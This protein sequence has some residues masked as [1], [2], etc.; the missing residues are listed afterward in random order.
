MAEERNQPQ[1]N[2][3]RWSRLKKSFGKSKAKR[4]LPQTSKKNSIAAGKKSKS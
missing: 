4:S 3:K 1:R 2:S